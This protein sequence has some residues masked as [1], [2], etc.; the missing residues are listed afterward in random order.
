VGLFVAPLLAVPSVMTA[1]TGQIASPPK[2]ITR[3]PSPARSPRQQPP[4]PST[5]RT[6]PPTKPT[7]I[8]ARSDFA[9]REALAGTRGGALL[10]DLVQEFLEWAD[11]RFTA[12]VF[13]AEMSREGAQPQRERIAGE[14]VRAL[15]V[16][17][18]PGLDGLRVLFSTPPCLWAR[19]VEHP[20]TARRKTTGPSY[21]DR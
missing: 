4:T 12:R 1:G 11:L 7:G 3:E 16:C 18:R 10:L 15:G 9:R 6:A 14:L 21:G 5:P 20:Q 17:G 2:F 8:A 13:E 19:P